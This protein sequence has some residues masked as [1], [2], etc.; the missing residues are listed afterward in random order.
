ML[1]PV[2]GQSR[3]AGVLHQRF[4]M[5]EVLAHMHNQA[6]KAETERCNVFSLV[7]SL[8]QR[9]VMIGQLPVFRIDLRDADAD[10]TGV[11]RI[12]KASAEKGSHREAKPPVDRNMRAFRIYT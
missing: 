11:D 4:F 5:P 10:E 12:K 2:K 7:Q 1:S 9:I 6:I 3:I 8:K